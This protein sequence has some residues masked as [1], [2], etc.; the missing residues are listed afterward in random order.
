M[1][2]NKILET[3]TLEEILEYNDLDSEDVVETLHIHDPDFKL[4]PLPTDID[5]EP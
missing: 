3:Y 1:D 5:Y 4:P 2:Y